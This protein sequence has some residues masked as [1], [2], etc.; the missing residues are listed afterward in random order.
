MILPYR[1]GTEG[2]LQPKAL[3]AGLALW[4]VWRGESGDHQGW[5][6]EVTPRAARAAQAPRG[7]CHQQHLGN[8]RAVK[9]AQRCP[10]VPEPA[11]DLRM[12]I[13]GQTAIE[14]L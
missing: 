5:G 10:Q 11:A 8:V 7:Q 14:I 9:A 6:T 13:Q 3:L 1:S 4:S 2:L 12:C